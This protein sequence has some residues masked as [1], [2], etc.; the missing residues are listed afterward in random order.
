MIR[1]VPLEQE[2]LLQRSA[3]NT[4]GEA[5]ESS[6]TL[7]WT[8]TFAAQQ[9]DYRQEKELLGAS[10]HAKDGHNAPQKP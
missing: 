3:G 5:T 4:G 9:T 7:W 6:R 10:I 8:R 1:N 2:P